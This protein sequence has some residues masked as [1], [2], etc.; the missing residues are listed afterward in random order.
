MSNN[1][2][3]I[4]Y[5][6]DS[7]NVGDAWVDLLDT[8]RPTDH[9]IVFYSDKSHHLS[10]ES[11]RR[12]MENGKDCISWILCYNDNPNA[13]DFQLVTELGSMAAKGLS[14]EYVIV[15]N[16]KGFDSVVRYWSREGKNIRRIKDYEC[17]KQTHKN[18][19]VSVGKPAAQ[20]SDSKSPVAAEQKHEI[21]IG[22]STAPSSNSRPPVTAEQK[23][24][25]TLPEKV[26]TEKI[27]PVKVKAAQINNAEAVLTPNIISVLTVLCKSIPIEQTPLLS[28]SLNALFSQHQGSKIYNRLK[29]LPDYCRTLTQKLIPNKNKRIENYISLV[30]RLN[31]FNSVDALDVYRIYFKRKKYDGNKIRSEL[32]KEFGEDEGAK[33]FKALKKHYSILNK[34]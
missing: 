15:S 22:K 31:K 5:L 9:I 14:D 26:F 6:I 2:N 13:L 11:V 3:N 24:V 1:L 4:C 34:I 29:E 20:S 7:E 8:L 30:L 16:D 25:K 10:C 23:Q 19:G 18:D 32:I 33:I 27:T 28:N 21:P 17:A 12:I